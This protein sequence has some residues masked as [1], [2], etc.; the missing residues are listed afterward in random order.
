MGTNCQHC[1]ICYS[2]LPME[3]RRDMENENVQ[4]M[5]IET[6]EEIIENNTDVI[7]DES[8]NEDSDIEQ[9]T[10]TEVTEEF[11]H[12]LEEYI[13]QQMEEIE[14]DEEDKEI[15]SEDTDKTLLLDSEENL[16]SINNDLLSQILETD[17]ETKDEIVN[18]SIMMV[19][20]R[21]SNMLTSSIEEITLDNFLTIVLITTILFTSVLSFA[22]RIF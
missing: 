3:V 4:D 21:Q 5:T 16:Q 14:T 8:I 10:D 20:Q 2:S 9:N 18:Q 15:T 12:L 19:D 22:R 17:L 1:S 6:T 13:K 11:T 7:I